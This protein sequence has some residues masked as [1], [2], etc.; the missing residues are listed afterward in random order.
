MS[1]H[2]AWWWETP[3]GRFFDRLSDDLDPFTP[4]DT[5]RL[6]GFSHLLAEHR[7]GSWMDYDWSHDPAQ[8]EQEALITRLDD[9]GNDEDLSNLSDDFLWKAMLSLARAERF[10][11]GLINAHAVGMTRLANEARVRLLAERASEERQ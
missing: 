5:G 11:E 3:D 6:L 4:V 2:R 7:S 8:P 1:A 10:N 9:R